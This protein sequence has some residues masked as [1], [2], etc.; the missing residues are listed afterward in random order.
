M[1]RRFCLG[2][3]PSRLHLVVFQDLSHCMIVLRLALRNSPGRCGIFTK[4]ASQLSSHQDSSSSFAQRCRFSIARESIR[5][6]RTGFSGACGTEA[7]VGATNTQAASKLDSLICLQTF[8]AARLL[9]ASL[10]TSFAVFT[11]L[12]LLPHILTP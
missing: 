6:N 7:L 4:T 12:S 1:D 9:R 11:S 2:R 3:A 10:A 8:L 5:G